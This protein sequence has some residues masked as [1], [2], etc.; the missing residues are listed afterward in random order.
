[1]EAQFHNEMP[2][3]STDMLANIVMAPFSV[4]PHRIPTHASARRATERRLIIN[5]AGGMLCSRRD[6][7]GLKPKQGLVTCIGDT[8]HSQALLIGNKSWPRYSSKAGGCVGRDK[9]DKSVPPAFLGFNH[10]GTLPGLGVQSSKTG[11]TGG[12]SD[13]FPK[14]ENREA[15]SLF[16]VGTDELF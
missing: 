1:M 14:R 3:P 10:T 11:A 15:I 16:S 2:S 4:G 7:D 13:Q 8:S 12:W 9:R 5:G 6:Y